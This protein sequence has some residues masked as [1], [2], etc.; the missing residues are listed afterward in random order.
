MCD[1]VSIFPYRLPVAGPLSALRQAVWHEAIR[2]MRRRKGQNADRLG[3]QGGK[4]ALGYP[5]WGAASGT[6]LRATEATTHRL[7]AEPLL[8]EP[9]PLRSESAPTEFP[10][11]CHRP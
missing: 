6:H 3:T 5:T 9:L 11:R 8:S 10:R 2:I 7:S 1:I 4:Y